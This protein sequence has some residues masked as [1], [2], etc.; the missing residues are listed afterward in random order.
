MQALQRI[1]HPA[2]VAAYEASQP[3]IN[4]PHDDEEV[5]RSF[6]D[7]MLSPEVRKLP[8]A[9]RVNGLDLTCQHPGGQSIRVHIDPHEKGSVVRAEGELSDI[10]GAK[11]ALVHDAGEQHEEALRNFGPLALAEIAMHGDPIHIQTKA[12]ALPANATLPL[13]N[14]PI[15]ERRESL[16]RWWDITG[17]PA[18]AA[19]K[20][21]DTSAEFLL[22]H[23]VDRTAAKPLV[24]E[25]DLNAWLRQQRSNGVDVQND[26]AIKSAVMA[27]IRYGEPLPGIKAPQPINASVAKTGAVISVALKNGT[28]VSTKKIGA[29]VRA[30][31][32]KTIKAEPPATIRAGTRGGRLVPVNSKQSSICGK[33]KCGGKL[34]PIASKQSPIASKARCGGKLVPMT[35]EPSLIAGRAKT[36]GASEDLA[37]LRRKTAKAKL[38]WDAARIK[39]AHA[40]EDAALRRFLKKNRSDKGIAGRYSASK[41]VGDKVQAAQPEF[42]LGEIPEP[43]Q[44]KF[45]GASVDEAH[46]LSEG[47]EVW[48]VPLSD[49]D[50]GSILSEPTSRIGWRINSPG[51]GHVVIKTMADTTIV[52]G[53]SERG[54]T[55]NHPYFVPLH[56]AKRGV[57]VGFVH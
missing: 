19:G 7:W 46:R 17:G 44:M 34:V 36:A 47:R 12:T 53:G 8:Y 6:N 1:Y 27:A 14:Q 42:V 20:S 55:E 4:D 40:K 24:A 39:A 29:P 23:A 25:K 33:A 51:D 54:A 32:T 35:S 9:V 43:L 15:E 57:F 50:T 21:I 2:T 16:S 10:I 45:I 38:E 22:A 5:V 30:A 11:V 49:S 3:H 56:D 13:W 52:L 37:R 28:S 26:V 31:Q 48:A 18:A 41:L